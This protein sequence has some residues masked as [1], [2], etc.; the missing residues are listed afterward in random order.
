MSRFGLGMR[1]LA[2][3]EGSWQT[4]APR[5]MPLTISVTS[6]CGNMRSYSFVSLKQGQAAR[7]AVKAPVKARPKEKKTETTT[8]IDSAAPEKKPRAKASTKA[9]AAIAAKPVTLAG[10]QPD[11]AAT[12]TTTATTNTAAPASKTP[13]PATQSRFSGPASTPRTPQPLVN[14]PGTAPSTS[15]NARTTRPTIPVDPESPADPLGS[16]E[17]QAGRNISTKSPEYQ[18]AKRQWVSLMVALPI[19]LVTSYFLYER[20]KLLRTFFH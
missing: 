12:A 10:S 8:A 17:Y 3:Y 5:A 2:R 14:R 19:V 20:C 7:R 4:A 6:N 13:A 16:D 1:M 15:P 9:D 18:K 11:T